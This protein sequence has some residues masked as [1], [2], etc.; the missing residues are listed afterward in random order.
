[1]AC[2]LW[3]YVEEAASGFRVSVESTCKLFFTRELASSLAGLREALKPVL[4]GFLYEPR[5]GLTELNY[6]MPRLELPVTPC[7]PGYLPQ[8]YPP[9]STAD[10][11]VVLDTR[12]RVEVYGLPYR[13]AAVIATTKRTLLEG[14]GYLV[15]AEPLEVFD[16][17]TVAARDVGFFES[18]WPLVSD[19][20]HLPIYLCEASRGYGLTAWAHCLE[21]SRLPET[22]VEEGLKQARHNPLCRPRVYASLA[23][24]SGLEPYELAKG[25]E[26]RL[27]RDSGGVRAVLARPDRLVFYL[28]QATST[29]YIVA[30]TAINAGE[31]LLGDWEEYSLLCRDCWLPISSRR[32]EVE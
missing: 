14:T 25:V 12:P 17:G 6:T 23:T 5:G 28:K 26:L 11:E 18:S 10:I 22:I 1:M 3:I 30:K 21:E 7:R 4:G 15:L 9:Y 13:R 20:R 29:G 19:R 2:S 32:V 8:P 31:T 16:D 27:W 24:R